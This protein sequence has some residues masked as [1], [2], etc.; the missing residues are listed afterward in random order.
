VRLVDWT[1]W[2]AARIDGFGPGWRAL[3]TRD[4]VMR[5]VGAE[6]TAPL[7]RSALTAKFAL[8]GREL[9]R[10]GADAEA[11]CADDDRWV[12]IGDDEWYDSRI[13]RGPRVATVGVFFDPDTVA[14]ARRERGTA[15][16][17]LLDD[18]R[19]P[20]G[21][22][23]PEPLPIGRRLLPYDAALAAAARALAVDDDPDARDELHALALDRILA[24]AGTAAAERDRLPCVRASTRAELHRRLARAHD[25]IMAAYAEPLELRELAR[26]AA[27]APHHFLRRFRDVF[28]A[29]PHRVLTA[30]RVERASHLLAHSDAP[31]AAIARAVGFATPASF[32]ARFHRET[33]RSP[34]AFRRRPPPR[35]DDTR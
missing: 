7:R 33:G 28:G 21:D 12:V 30:R 4:L 13:P 16:P 31:I 9:Y 29:T 35:I 18:P 22:P 5:G 1:G 6:M 25:R 20:A 17:R 11:V 32:A 2:S 24:A 19:M 15:E 34:R 3:A 23:A 27:M 26:V 10:V 14:A 8:G